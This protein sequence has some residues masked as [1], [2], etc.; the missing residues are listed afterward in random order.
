MS[1]SQLKDFLD[2]GKFGLSNI[3]KAALQSLKYQTASE[4]VRM[5]EKIKTGIKD[6]LVQADKKRHTVKHSSIVTDAAR[7]A[8]EDKKYV[9]EV[10]SQI[11]EQTGQW[12]RDLGKIADFVLHQ[13]FDEGRAAA[14][15]R[16]KGDNAL[17][18]KTPYPGACQYC[19]KAYLTGGVGSMPKVFTVSELRENG[20]NVGKKVNDWLPVIGASHVFCR[21]TLN[22]APDGMTLQN[23]NDWEWT[24]MVFKREAKERRERPKAK[25]IIGNKTI[26]V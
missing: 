19:I 16:E 22:K 7:K 5:G 12:N 25:V 14:A 15:V 9:K 26:E 11:G 17:V 8:I 21:C 1:Y 4:V 18:Y 6:M 24:G 10:V 23:M 13:A 20:T 3:E 2:K